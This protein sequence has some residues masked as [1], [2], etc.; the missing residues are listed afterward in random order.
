MLTH[1]VCSFAYSVNMGVKLPILIKLGIAGW[2]PTEEGSRAELDTSLFVQTSCHLRAILFLL[3]HASKSP[4]SPSPSGFDH[5]IA[6]SDGLGAN[7]VVSEDP[8][9]S[10]VRSSKPIRTKDGFD[11]LCLDESGLLLRNTSVSPR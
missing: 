6:N 5:S 9:G 7:L 10:D 2:V 4:L 1:A 8:E 3:P 11:I